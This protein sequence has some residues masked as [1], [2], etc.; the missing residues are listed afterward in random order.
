MDI[1]TFG[2]ALDQILLML[3]AT[4]M[5]VPIFEHPPRTESKGKGKGKEK[6]KAQKYGVTKH[7]YIMS[8]PT[9]IQRENRMGTLLSIFLSAFLQLQKIIIDSPSFLEKSYRIP[10]TRLPVSPMAPV[11]NLIP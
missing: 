1:S 4:D 10:N 9:K 3:L 8:G 5:R 2:Q 7:T 6:Q 11:S